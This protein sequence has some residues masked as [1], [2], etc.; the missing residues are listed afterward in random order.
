MEKG[1]IFRLAD[2]LYYDFVKKYGYI[3]SWGVVVRFLRRMDDWREISDDTK[4]YIYDYACDNNLL[5]N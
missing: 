1:M 5:G 3:I 2:A 4:D